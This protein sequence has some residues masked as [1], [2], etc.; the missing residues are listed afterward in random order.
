MLQWNARGIRAHGDELITH[1]K[2]LPTLPHVICVQESFLKPW[3]KKKYKVPGYTPIRQ[4]REVGEK[5]GLVILIRKGLDYTENDVPPDMEC[6][7]IRVYFS[8]TYVNVSNF[9]QSGRNFVALSKLDKLFQ[10][11]RHIICGDFNAHSPLWGH[12]GAEHR[13]EGILLEEFCDKY[14][15]VCKNDGRPTYI[16]ALGVMTALDLTFVSRNISNQCHWDV[17]DNCFSSDHFPVST[18]F[19]SNNTNCVPPSDVSPVKR[20]NIR[21]GN[22]KVYQQDLND[23]FK[24]IDCNGTAIEVYDRVV[25]VI[26]DVSDRCLP[27]SKNSDPTKK[28]KKRMAPWWTDECE[29]ATRDKFNALNKYRRTQILAD[30]LRYKHCRGIAKSVI[31]KA[32]RSS[33]RTFSSK[34]SK[35]SNLG[36]VWNVLKSMDGRSYQDQPSIPPIVIDNHSY[37]SDKN[38]ADIIGNSFQMVSSS[39][40]YTATFLDHKSEFEAT[41]SCPSNS[42]FRQ[43]DNN[44]SFNEPLSLVELKQALA[45]TANTS[46]GQDGISYKMLK[47]LNDN[48]LSTLLNVYNK[49]WQSGILPPSWNHSIVHPILKKDKPPSAPTSYRP[50][51]LTSCLCK[52]M[53]KVI[54]SRL[55]WYLESH[56]LFCDAQSGFRQGRT[57][58]DHIS[59]LY[60][61][62]NIQLK[63]QGLMKAIFVDLE[64]AF[65]MVWHDGLLCKLDRL[66]VNGNMFNWIQKFLFR[67]TFQVMIGSSLSEEFILENG[68]PQGSVISPILFSIMV[69]DIP[70]DTTIS[71]SLYADDVAL[72]AIGAD[73]ADVNRKLQ[74]NLNILSNWCDQWGFKIS[75]KKTQAITFTR[76]RKRLDTR[77]ILNGDVVTFTDEVKF[78]GVTFDKTLTFS[79]HIKSVIAKCNKRYNLLKCLSGTSWGASKETLLITYRGLIRSILDYASYIYTNISAKNRELLERI[80]NKS[81]R[82]ICGATPKTPNSATQVDLGELPLKLR[83][84]FLNIIYAIKVVESRTHP[85]YEAFR[86]IY[87]T[88]IPTKTLGLLYQTYVDSIDLPYI[89]FRIPP[90]PP[91]HRPRVKVDTG[92]IML[93]GK[94]QSAYITR[95]CVLQYIGRFSTYL[96][97]YTD[98]SKMEEKVAF[99]VYVRDFKIQISHRLTDYLNIFTAELFA[100]Y[101]ALLWVID[102]QPSRVVIYSDSLSSLNSISSYHSN[103][104]PYLLLEIYSCLKEIY[105]LGIDIWFVWVPAHVGL[106]GNETADNLAKEGIKIQSP[107]IS[108]PLSVSEIKAV[109][110]SY[111]LRKWQDLWDSSETGKFYRN[112][113]PLVSNE[114]KFSDPDRQL[115]TTLTRLRFNHNSLNHNRFR[116]GGYNPLCVV[117]Q[118]D[119]TIEHYLFECL[120]YIDQQV[121]TYYQFRIRGIPYTLENMLGAHRLGTVFCYEYVNNT[122]RFTS[123]LYV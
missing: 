67:R 78:L 16:G 32:K 112:L 101:Y 55:V 19:T 93:V 6:Q 109:V 117:C 49:I 64:K 98:G 25:E 2:T 82:L 106:A 99:G 26:T 92:L 20:W 7:S 74:H 36:M 83:W 28:V 50:I 80:Q 79:S 102:V 4:D 85:A 111:F 12:M 118:E 35:K 96:P 87:H 51:S 100:I 75:T 8:G 30:Y 81:L 10:L 90:Q 34:F 39:D 3:H 31:K 61:D 18:V 60:N 17:F 95:D 77:L 110:K 108:I 13:K 14:N 42:S 103:S 76:K 27:S 68:T 21:K 113:V 29:K 84:D 56:G 69:N 59:K 57:T 15:Y 24:N 43:V 120:R 63:H 121:Y 58:H 115:E 23:S 104:R 116:I 53:E 41:S 73:E 11:D 52:L 47:L 97:I 91:W 44:L 62:A 114:I 119:E 66:G 1:L 105:N 122:G 71:K 22:L 89:C 65:D 107:S 38:K 94:E 40:N 70:F 37:V 5:G 88:N 45:S 54:T 46:P 33:W 123:N 9:Y 48:S 72:W 86:N